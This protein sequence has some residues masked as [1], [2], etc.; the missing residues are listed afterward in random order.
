VRAVE[1][2]RSLQQ[3]PD[4]GELS[5]IFLVVRSHND[6]PAKESTNSQFLLL[7]TA[8]FADSFFYP[9]GDQRV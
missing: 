1:S 4:A 3:G 5:P 8:L 2:L 6:P 7:L 9:F